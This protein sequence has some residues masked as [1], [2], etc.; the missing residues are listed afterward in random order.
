M[1]GFFPLGKLQDNSAATELLAPVADRCGS[2]SSC[3]SEAAAGPATASGR[4]LHR[5]A[6]I[7]TEHCNIACP[8]CYEH[9]EPEVFYHPTPSKRYMSA[10]SVLDI[11]RRAYSLWPHIGALF[12]FGGEPLVKKSLIKRVCEAV[13]NGEVEGIGTRPR[14]AMITN[15]TLLDAD[16]AEMIARHNFELNI[17]LDGPP[18]VNDMTRIDHSG[19]GTSRITLENLRRLR[20][21]G[22]V[23]RIEATVSRFHLDSGVSATDLMDYFYDEHGIGVLHAPW[24]SAHPDDPYALTHDEIVAYYEPAIRYSMANLRKGI[25]KVIFLVDE[26]LRAMRNYSPNSGRAYC[27]AC[28]SDISVNPAGDIYP[29]FMFNG[30]QYLKLGN[31]FD[32][33]FGA[34]LNY[35]ALQGFYASIFGPCNCPPEYQHFHSGC[36]GADRIATNSIL[37]KPYCDVQTRLL[38]VFLEEFS[39][40]LSTVASA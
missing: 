37:S 2:V 8:Y 27:P 36:V 32:D 33:Q 20:S 13:E 11:L 26:W 31:V 22:I 23:Y 28:F 24:V 25:P 40:P 34:H 16:A 12:F 35:R 14:F 1:D 38:E 3:S 19:N 4:E 21:M 6:I 18:V 5:L 17:S 39:H 9:R 29:C 7:L 15:A 30:Y 10:D